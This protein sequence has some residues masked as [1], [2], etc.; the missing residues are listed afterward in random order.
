MTMAEAPLIDKLREVPIFRGLDEKELHRIAA[1]GKE[2]NF[3]AGK[4]VAEQDGGAA[5]FHLILDGEVSVD[6][7]GVER[8][9][10]RKGQYFG[11]MSL[12]DGKPRSATVKA[13]VP[14]TTFALTS[15]QFLPLLAE[16]PSISRALLV[17][18]SGRL[19]R[20]ENDPVG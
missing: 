17:E 2:V 5:G 15:W 13:E 19:R 16:Y 10:L 8:A 20:V 1:A 7:N 9:R 3:D 12:I 18:L 6:V 11:E 14:T 4:V